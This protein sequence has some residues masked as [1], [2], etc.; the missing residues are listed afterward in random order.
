M[1]GFNDKAKELM[2][3]DNVPNAKTVTA[4]I[5]DKPCVQPYQETVSWLVHPLSIPN[6][7]LLVAHRTGAGKTC[8][9]IRIFDNFFQGPATQNC[10]LSCTHAR[11]LASCER[12]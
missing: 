3:R 8:S 1:T 5:P 6:P 10:H 2:K 4:P 11:T 7:H 12:P 9:M